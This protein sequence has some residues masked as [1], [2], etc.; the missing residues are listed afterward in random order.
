MHNV[1]VYKPEGLIESRFCRLKVTRIQFSILIGCFF[2]RDKS[3]IELSF[4]SYNI[5]FSHGGIKMMKTVKMT[6]IAKLL[7]KATMRGHK[8]GGD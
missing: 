2:F 5:K 7:K 6:K 4:K 8:R 1:E 3:T